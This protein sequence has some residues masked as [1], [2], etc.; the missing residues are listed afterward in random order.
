MPAFIFEDFLLSIGALYFIHIM[1]FKP[2]KILCSRYDC[3]TCL[4]QRRKLTSNDSIT[5]LSTNREQELGIGSIDFTP[6]L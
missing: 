4:T 1:T 5:Y 6:C 3:S 2:F